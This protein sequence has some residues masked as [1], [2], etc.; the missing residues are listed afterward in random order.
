MVGLFCVLTPRPPL[1]KWRGGELVWCPLYTQ[2]GGE[3]VSCPHF[4]TACIYQIDGRPY[5]PIS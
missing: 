3:F 1:H 2:R 4:K 5:I